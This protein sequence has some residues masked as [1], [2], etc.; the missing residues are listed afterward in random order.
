MRLSENKP[1]FFLVSWSCILFFSHAFHHLCLS[2]LP[3]C[4]LIVQQ[5][6]AAFVYNALWR[7]MLSSV[8]CLP[9]VRVQYA[10]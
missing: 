7:L 8:H 2:S 9:E 4:F 3:P 1:R 10:P 5:L 6:W